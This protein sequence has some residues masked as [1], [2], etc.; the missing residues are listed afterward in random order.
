VIIA[1]FALELRFWPLLGLAVIFLLLIIG[2]LVVHI[3]VRDLAQMRVQVKD[4]RMLAGQLEA[5]C[6]RLTDELSEIAKSAPTAKTIAFSV[7]HDVS[8]LCETV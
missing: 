5:R 8:Q 1:S 7:N 2:L 6:E 4:T 3:L